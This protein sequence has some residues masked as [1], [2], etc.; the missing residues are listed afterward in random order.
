MADGALIMLRR[1]GNA[2]GPRL[3]LSHGNGL[4]ADLYY[5]FWSLF[6]D[7]YDI[8]LYDFRSHG[9]NPV[10]DRRV[11]NIPTFV[12]DSQYLAQAI[13]ARFSEK[14][15]I[16]IFHSLS[17]LTALLHG[18]AESA[19]S[20]LVLFDP[21]VCPP[22]RAPEDFEVTGQQMAQRA[23][24]RHDRFA[25]RAEYADILRRSQSFARMQSDVPELFAHTTL[26]I[27]AES[28]Y[29]LCCPREYEAQIYEYVFGLRRPSFLGH[30]LRDN[31]M[32]KE[33]GHGWVE[34]SEGSCVGADGGSPEGERSRRRR[35]GGRRVR[36][37]LQP[38]LAP[39]E[40]GVSHAARS[41]RGIR[42]TPCRVAQTCVQE[43]GCGTRTSPH[44]IVSGGDLR[45]AAE[46]LDRS[47]YGCS[48]PPVRMAPEASRSCR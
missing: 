38:V 40:A 29:E 3:V 31:P 46:R 39:R 23:R 28:G 34:A 48:T 1:H 19:F 43:T 8:I 4:A 13:D 7:R 36:R 2:A 26:R 11:H 35:R 6:T 30:G 12:R 47:V 21:P 32:S 14:P 44:N 10:G 45:S 37:T 15:K 18:I 16:G 20:A 17:A 5:P 41:A 33:V 27:A 25:T 42:A 24:Q 9:W 22:G